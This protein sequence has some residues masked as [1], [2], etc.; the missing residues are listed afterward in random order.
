[1][2]TLPG[3]LGTMAPILDQYGYLAV[4]G[5]I[6]VEDFGVPAPGE[7]ILIT[8]AVYAGAG[9]LNVALVAL[10]AFAAA[11]AGDNI[12][13]AIGRYG[14]RRLAKR[15][16]RY[17]LLTPRRLDR[18]DAFMS[19]HGGKVVTIAR[20][21]EG[22]RQANGIIAGTTGMTWRRFL[23]YNT[24]GAALWVSAWSA[25][26]TLAGDHITVIYQDAHRYGLYLVIGVAV[27]VAALLVRHLVGRHRAGKT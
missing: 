20:F 2:T 12:G 4:G 26:G 13:F 10:V 27:V 25:L 24:A 21:I 5:M 9:K 14:G 18:A 16:G 7:T 17:V 15:L 6:L 8:A 22:L 3:F 11:V 23:I 19:R 1:M